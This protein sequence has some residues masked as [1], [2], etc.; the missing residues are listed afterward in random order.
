MMQMSS[1]GFSSAPLRKMRS[2]SPPKI[3]EQQQSSLT[4][5]SAP[6]RRMRSASP[7]KKLEKARPTAKKK[8]KKRAQW[9]LQ[10]VE[11]ESVEEKSLL[12]ESASA[13]VNESLSF[14]LF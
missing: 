9:S 11:T 10:K 14:A 1:L 12:F 13:E 6:R 5:S 3:L 8:R 7:A 4:F 2:A